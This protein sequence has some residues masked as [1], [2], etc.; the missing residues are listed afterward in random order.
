MLVIS[1]TGPLRYLVELNA[2]DILQDL[3]GRTGVMTTPQVMSELR[4]S[5]F[6]AAVQRWG[7]FPPA[8]LQ[9]E[10]PKTIEFLDRLDVGEA[11]AIS[12]A[13]ERRAD[14]VLIDE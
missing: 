11:S 3:Y 9:I 2:I 13:E 1:D 6:P 10:S 7:T 5:H 8:W 12:L 4:L 14:L